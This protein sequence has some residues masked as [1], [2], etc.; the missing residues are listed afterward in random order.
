MDIRVISIGAMAAHELWNEREPVRTGHATT[1]L[2]RTADAVI[3]VDPGLPA[4]AL[5]ARLGERAGIPPEAV[6]HV[7]LTSFRSEAR[8]ALP[9]FESAEWFISHAEREAVGTPLATDLKRLAESGLLD[10][11]EADDR[12]LLAAIQH[13]I[14]LLQRCRPAPDRL[15]PGVDLFPLPGVTPG[16]TGL[17]VPSPRGDTLIAGDAIPPRAH[18]ERGRVPARSADPAAAR[19]SLLEAIEIADVLVPGRDNILLNPMRRPFPAPGR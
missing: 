11:P 13:E 6:T 9:L 1:T 10:D 5:G 19:E 16:L 12:A 7:F 18:R 3:L 4:Q 8:R 17:L 2:I 14:G 15:V